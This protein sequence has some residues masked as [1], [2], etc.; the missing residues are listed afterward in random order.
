ML[1]RSSTASLLETVVLG[2]RGL[3][4][5]QIR[6]GIFPQLQE[7]FVLLTRGRAVAAY[8]CGTRQL[9]IN[10]SASNEVQHDTTS[11]LYGVSSALLS[12]DDLTL[13]RF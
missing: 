10:Q 2:L 13:S 6:I 4:D 9:K 11:Q 12:S 1:T 7:G 3:E 8:G 5:W